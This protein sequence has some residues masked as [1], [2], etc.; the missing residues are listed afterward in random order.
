MANPLRSRKCGRRKPRASRQGHGGQGEVGSS[1]GRIR[2]HD[3]HAKWQRRGGFCL[4][5]RQIS[6][7]NRRGTQQGGSMSET[8]GWCTPENRCLK[9]S[10][11][12]CAAIASS[13]TLSGTTGIS[14]ATSESAIHAACFPATPENKTKQVKALPAQPLPAGAEDQ[15]SPEVRQI[16][17][18]ATKE[19]CLVP[20]WVED[21]SDQI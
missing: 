8:K 4:D 2:L 5:D 19:I 3:I 16:A 14:G 7:A 12:I 13:K 17:E 20:Y 6:E 21:A 1:Q 10:C 11:P 18:K 15:P 9:L